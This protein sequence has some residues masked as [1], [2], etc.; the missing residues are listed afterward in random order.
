MGLSRVASLHLVPLITRIVLCAVFVPIG[1]NKIM[2]TDTFTGEEAVTIRRLMSESPMEVAPPE[3]ALDTSA[4]TS[5][6][7]DI[8]A[9]RVYSLAFMLDSHGVRYPV[10]A[11]WLTATVELVGGGLLLI[12]LF[13]RVWGIGLAIAMSVAFAL[14]SWPIIS[15]VGPFALEM[16]VFNSATAQIA[17]A[18]LGLGIFLGGPGGIA[19]DHGIFGRHHRDHGATREEETPAD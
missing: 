18:T 14:T 2:T 19:I 4:E 11:A 13:S 5:P 3:N 9:R 17:L 8:E 15:N 6:A 7:E 12:G 10:I 1:W 16:P